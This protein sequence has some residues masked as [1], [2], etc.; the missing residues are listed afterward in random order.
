M[1]FAYTTDGSLTA[2]TLWLASGL[3]AINWPLEDHWKL[4]G[5][6]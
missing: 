1:L 4:L 5:S 2:T 6:A 3:G